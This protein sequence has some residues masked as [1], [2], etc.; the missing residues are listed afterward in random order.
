MIRSSASV[1]QTS[2]L[3]TL[4]VGEDFPEAR[5]GQ[6]VSVETAPDLTLLRPFAVAG[7]P[8]PDAIDLLVEVRGRGTRALAEKPVGSSVG[9]IGPLGNGF[10]PPRPGTVPL[11]VAGGIGVAGLRMHAQELARSST[12]QLILVGAKTSALLLAGCLPREGAEHGV[13]IRTAT[14]D[15]SAGYRGSV[16]SLLLETLDGAMVDGGASYTVYCCGPPGMISSTAAVT[17]ERAVPCEA[18]LEEK[19]ACG[20][21]ACRGCVVETRRGYRCVCSDGP[22]FDVADLVLE[23]HPIA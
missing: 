8:G 15:G 2:F 20:V 18:L 11:L 10:T 5:P 16:T 21:G 12:R 17:T 14:D 9:L 13:M 22:V 19:M 4:D 6:F 7:R 23:E 3:L 1:S